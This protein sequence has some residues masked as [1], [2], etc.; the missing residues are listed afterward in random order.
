MGLMRWGNTKLKEAPII[1]IEGLFIRAFNFQG[2]GVDVLAGL[3]GGFWKV[4]WGFLH[5]DPG[6]GRAVNAGTSSVWID[7]LT[8]IYTS[9]EISIAA[10]LYSLT[11]PFVSLM[12]YAATEAPINSSIIK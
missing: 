10:L 3:C 5:C 11:L 12:V 8:G 6:N 4:E 1:Y 2:R 9:R 7:D